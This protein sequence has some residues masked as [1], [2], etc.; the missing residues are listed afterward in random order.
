VIEA[1][2][3]PTA[4]TI[5]AFDI[6]FDT[7][8]RFYVELGN[9]LKRAQISEVERQNLSNAT[10]MYIYLFV[11]IIKVIDISNASNNDGK[12]NNRK[13]NKK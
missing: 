5:R 11:T 9:Q 8:D 1:S 6:L 2:D 7:L 12:T 3:C 10:K 13:V 4:T